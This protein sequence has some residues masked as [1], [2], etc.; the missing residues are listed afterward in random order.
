M[1]ATSQSDDW[2]PNPENLKLRPGWEAA[3]WAGASQPDEIGDMVNAAQRSLEAI[4]TLHLRANAALL[5]VAVSWRAGKAWFASRRKAP[6]LQPR[7]ADAPSR[8]V[9][10]CSPC[11]ARRAMMRSHRVGHL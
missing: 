2:Q 4:L 7:K 11:V 1:G 6:A 3:I 8:E 9:P 10:I 5:P